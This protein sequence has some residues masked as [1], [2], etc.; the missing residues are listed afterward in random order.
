MPTWMAQDDQSKTITSESFAVGLYIGL[1]DWIRFLIPRRMVLSKILTQSPSPSGTPITLGEPRGSRLHVNDA[2]QTSHF[3]P[4][5]SERRNILV[6]VE[7]AWILMEVFPTVKY[8]FRKLEY[9]VELMTWSTAM[10]K[11]KWS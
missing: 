1:R 8:T 3:P 7:P 9:P 11:R 10:E 5:P 4:C 6:K 2:L